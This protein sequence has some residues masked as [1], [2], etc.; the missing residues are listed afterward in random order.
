M[1][2]LVILLAITALTY[3]AENC[4]VYTC[5]D[6]LPKDV[7]STKVINPTNITYTMKACEGDNKVC[8]VRLKEK[9]QCADFYDQK[10]SYPGEYCRNNK[11][12]FKG[13]CPNETHVCTLNPGNTTCED[14]LDC[15]PG[16]FC[17]SGNCV[18]QKMF[19]ETCGKEDRCHP[20]FACNDSLCIKVGS[21]ENGQKASSPLVCKSFYV[22]EGVC[23]EGPKLTNYTDDGLK[24]PESNLCTYTIDKH[25]FTDKCRCGRNSAGVKYCQPG[26]GDINMQDVSSY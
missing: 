8:D 20:S 23:K 14:D 10:L 18:K 1:K 9:D 13:N 21:G 3:A 7:C 6:D 22:E 16:L 12:C 19:N 11:E 4:L 2:S 15:N 24:C 25:D 26:R 17:K 5:K